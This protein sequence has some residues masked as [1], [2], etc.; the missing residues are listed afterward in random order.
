MIWAM[1]TNW[2]GAIIFGVLWIVVGVGGGAIWAHI[3]TKR[4]AESYQSALVALHATSEAVG[5]EADPVQREAA[6]LKK[7]ATYDWRALVWIRKNQ[8]RTPFIWQ[9]L[10]VWER[11]TFQCTSTR[12]LPYTRELA[13]SLSVY[14]DLEPQR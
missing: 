13:Y 12:L 11:G 8:N 2:N 10:V 7:G 4:Q 14:D 3:G 9:S 5:L 1:R 6:L